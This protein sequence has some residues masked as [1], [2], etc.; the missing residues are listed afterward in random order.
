[1][2]APLVFHENNKQKTHDKLNATT[3]KSIL[4]LITFEIEIYDYKKNKVNT[5]QPSLTQ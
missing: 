1:M 4:L 3:L 2:K 5:V